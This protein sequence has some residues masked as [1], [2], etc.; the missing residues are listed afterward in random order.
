MSLFTIGDLHLSLGTNKPMDIFGGWA[1]Y[2]AR[3][4]QNWNNLVAENDTVIIPGDISWAMSLPESLTDLRFI[5][6]ELPGEKILLKGNHDYWWNTTAKMNAFLSENG[7]S[8]IKILHN[9]AY[10]RGNIA[11]CGTRGWINDDGAPADQKILLREAGRLEISL[12]AAEK[13]GGEP[14]VFLHYPPIFAG[15]ENIYMLDIMEKHGV[16]RCYFGH[17]H[18]Y[19]I[20]KAFTGIRRGVEFRL[21]SADSL[22]FCPEQIPDSVNKL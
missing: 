19:A 15:N 7:L 21:I 13:L 17:L 3:L 8:N 10:L 2:V 5:S 18:G 9:N 12:S 22:G 16:K 1:N 6:G 14:V 20:K 11:I 4:K